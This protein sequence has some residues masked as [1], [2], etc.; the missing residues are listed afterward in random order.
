MQLNKPLLCL[1]TYYHHFIRHVAIKRTNRASYNLFELI[2]LLT[3]SLFV[4][5]PGRPLAT[6][7]PALGT[8]VPMSTT[9]TE[10][11]VVDAET[12]AYISIKDSVSSSSRAK[13]TCNACQ[14]SAKDLNQLI[15]WSSKH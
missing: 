14:F 10:T 6:I 4:F 9:I 8:H 7:T 11:I 12:E 5:S 3:F 13:Y 15:G 2:E 1:F